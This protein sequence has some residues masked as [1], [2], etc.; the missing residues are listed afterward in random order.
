MVLRESGAKDRSAVIDLFGSS[1]VCT[2]LGGPRP[3]DE[4][5]RAVPEIPGRRPGYFVVDLD[6]API[7]I[8]TFDRRD[9]ER[10]GHIRPEC[11]LPDR[12]RFASA[13]HHRMAEAATI[14]AATPD[15]LGDLLAVGRLIPD[16]PLSAF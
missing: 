16:Q 7:G 1:E 5:E 9:P 15:R 11:L 6:G 14:V 10:P 4:L 13:S 3:R 8:V 12:C 2:Y